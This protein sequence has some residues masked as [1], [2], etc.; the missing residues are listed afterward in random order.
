V[1]DAIR[2]VWS[3]VWYFR[4]FEERTYNGIDH[5]SVG[6]ALL[7]HHSFP[8]EE[9]N[10]VALTNNIFDEEGIE[11]AF[12]VNVQVGDESVVKPP[13][14]VNTDQYLHYFTAPNQP[15]TYLSSSS[16]V[17]LGEHVLSS[18]QV[19]ELGVALDAIHQGFSPA[20]GPASG[21]NGWYAMDVEF[22]FDDEWVD[23]PTGESVVHIKQARPHPGRGQ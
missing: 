8:T 18:K 1:L 13:A 5:L 3:S 4:S 2:E 19:H 11:P 6:M 12:Y 20:Y 14:G 9:A 21:N 22:K 10:G 7:V 23:N 16:R 17:P 15:V